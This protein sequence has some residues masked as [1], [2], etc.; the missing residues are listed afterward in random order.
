MS[1]SKSKQCQWC[2]NSFEYKPRS[3]EKRRMMRK[4]LMLADNAPLAYICDGCFNSHI[5]RS[6]LPEHLWPNADLVPNVLLR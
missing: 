1:P 4:S 5:N 2:L 3:E 6:G